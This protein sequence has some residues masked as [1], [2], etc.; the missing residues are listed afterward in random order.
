VLATSRGE[1]QP[2][3]YVTASPGDGWTR[4]DFDDSGWR[5]GQAGFGRTS[6]PGTRVRTP[7]TSPDLWLRRSFVL[8]PRALASPHV[9]VRHDE[10]AQIYLNGRLIM[11]LEGY[12]QAHAIVPLDAVAQA[13]LHPGDNLL[14]AHVRN[15]RGGQYFDAGI[16]EVVK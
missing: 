2:W 7:W 12:N 16:V 14:A 3:R 9:I 10:D 1:G 13:L 5:E 8:P 11:T 4:P 15:T 6:D